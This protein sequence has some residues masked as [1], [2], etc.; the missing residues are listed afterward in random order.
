MVVALVLT[1][2]N[3]GYNGCSP[4]PDPSYLS[5]IPLTPPPILKPD[6]DLA[7]VNLNH[8]GTASSSPL[9]QGASK[10]AVMPILK[11]MPMIKVPARARSRARR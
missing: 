3:Y 6:L 1:Q 11:P 10:S 5:S 9:D 7:A 4:S 8:E 2:A